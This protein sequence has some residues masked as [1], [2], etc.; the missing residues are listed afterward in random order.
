MDDK[1]EYGFQLESYLIR[2]A[3]ALERLCLVLAMT[4]LYLVSQ[5]TSVVKRG[6][7][8]SC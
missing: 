8:P 7:R 4:T 1:S 5:G 3:K 6:K 2:S